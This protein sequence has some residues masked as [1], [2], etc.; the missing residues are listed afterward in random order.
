MNNISLLSYLIEDQKI[1][2][3]TLQGPDG[4]TKFV[5]LKEYMTLLEN[6]GS[7]ISVRFPNESFFEELSINLEKF[8]VSNEFPHEIFGWYNGTAI[9]IKK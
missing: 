4:E 1:K 7:K 2:G 8:E 6:T 9:S 5:D 3:V